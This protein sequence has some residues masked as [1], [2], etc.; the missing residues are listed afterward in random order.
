MESHVRVAE[1]THVST[2]RDYLT[3]YLVLASKLIGTSASRKRLGR[4]RSDEHAERTH[5]NHNLDHYPRTE[6]KTKRCVVYEGTRRRKQL[7]ERGN[8]HES[9]T[10]CST[11]QVHFCTDDE[12]RCFEIYHTHGLLHLNTSALLC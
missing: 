2:R 7:P 6:A 9:R 8:R 3:F 10:L 1:H 11:C 4:P 5:L 12:R